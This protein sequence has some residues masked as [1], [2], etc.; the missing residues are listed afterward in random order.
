MKCAGMAASAKQQD[1]TNC[2]TGDKA[3]ITDNACIFYTQVLCVWRFFL[4]I[5]IF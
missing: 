5:L 1:Y 2:R 3:T 4:K